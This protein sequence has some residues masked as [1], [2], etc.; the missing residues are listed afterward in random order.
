VP[1]NRPGILYF[2]ILKRILAIER[3]RQPQQ[4]INEHI[5]ITPIR[6]ISAEGE[7]LGIIPTD[8]AL[9]LAREQGLDLVEVAP[10]E[11]PPVCRIMDFGKFKYQQRKRQ[12]RGHSHQTKVKEIRLHPKTGEHDI[13]FKVKQAR[14]FL[15][16]KDKVVITVLY[17]GRENAH[18]DVGIK[19]VEN[20]MEQLSDV[21]KV[22]QPP[23]YL[24]KKVS[25][26]MA[27]K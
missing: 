27:P 23:Q 1:L 15:E 6:V 3:E 20:V 8:K 21:G 10:E 4:R 5:R 13:A 22:E 14:Q 12:H 16:N 2:S 18:V 17:K 9:S 11:R 19:V 25:C 24:G 26:T 7:Q